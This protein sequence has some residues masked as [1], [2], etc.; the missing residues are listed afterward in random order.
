MKRLLTGTAALAVLMTTAASATKVKDTYLYRG[1]VWET[2]PA[3]KSSQD[4]Q[5]CGMQTRFNVGN[6]YYVVMI[7]YTVQGGMDVQ[8]F[9]STWNIPANAKVSLR[10]EF[11]ND[12]KPGKP[13]AISTKEA[14]VNGMLVAM[15]INQDDQLSFLAMFSD[16]TT[17]NIS[18]P[19]G[20]EKPWSIKMNEARDA[21][22][23]FDVCMLGL[24]GLKLPP[25]RSARRK[26]SRRK[27]KKEQVTC[28]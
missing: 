25:N 9:K 5:L 16:A 12:K 3:N 23:T 11:V 2:Y 26:P 22:N 19:E 20:S 15:P 13:M 24:E 1:K 7:K 21:V 6:R 10:V 18:F 8:A 28:K 17:I 4:R 14:D 27:G